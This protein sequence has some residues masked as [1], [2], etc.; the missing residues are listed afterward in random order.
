MDDGL[1]GRKHSES[2][3]HSLSRRRFLAG[4]TAAV[5]AAF[6]RGVPTLAQP[7]ERLTVPPGAPPVIVARVVHRTVNVG[8][9][10]NQKV[11]GVMIDTALIT[12]TRQPD[13]P[14]AW[15]QLLRPDDV[16]GIK[17]N[18]SGAEALGTTPAFAEALLGSLV[19]AGHDPANV[20]LI[21]ARE[22][23]TKLFSCRPALP[24]YDREATDF[25]SGADQLASVLNQVTAL[26]NVPFL[27]THHLT[28]ITC[29]LKNL[30]HGLIKHP[31][32]YHGGGCSPY[33]GDIVNLPPIRSKLRLNLVNALRVVFQ[34]GPEG[35]RD[36][37]MDAHSVLAS[38]DP[39][40]CDSVVMQILNDV[41]QT[42]GLAQI[43]SNSSQ[44]PYLAHSHRIGLGV[45]ATSGIEVIR[46]DL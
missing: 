42:R 23:L 15:R 39:V 34:G 26:I 17:F 30:S 24:G 19:R 2:P 32:R 16:V 43:A 38:T 6:A 33:I 13:A 27:K 8:A 14:A 41:R 12:L 18:R 37:I 11:L 1:D 25:G 36:S 29:A 20:V 28:G 45:A 31:A 4:S 46:V 35:G 10:V 21:E 3:G 9:T 7:A 44:L 40:A 5:G 22:G